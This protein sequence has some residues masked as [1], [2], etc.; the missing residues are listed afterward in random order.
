MKL[1]V[2]TAI[3]DIF[4]QRE[5]AELHQRFINSLSLAK[6]KKRKESAPKNISKFILPI[7]KL[8]RGMIKRI[9][10]EAIMPPRFRH[11]LNV[12]EDS[13]LVGRLK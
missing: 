5:S 4:F 12:V 8:I 9:N 1:K 6:R 11:K 10:I 3:I 13:T 2:A 7:L